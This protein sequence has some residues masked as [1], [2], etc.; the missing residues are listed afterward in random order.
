MPALS[1]KTDG[2]TLMLSVIIL[3]EPFTP[4]LLIG[5]DL[6]IIGILI[7]TIK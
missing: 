5:V 6:I 7:L 3:G 4:K 1:K 2:D